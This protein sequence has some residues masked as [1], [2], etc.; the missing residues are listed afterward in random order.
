VNF[1]SGFAST[2][3]FQ[4][5]LKAMPTKKAEIV[6]SHTYPHATKA[7]KIGRDIDAN[8]PYKIAPVATLWLRTGRW[9]DG[10]GGV[11]TATVCGR[12]SG[13]TLV[14]RLSFSDSRSPRD[15]TRRRPST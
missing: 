9:L 7:Q 4:A 10:V 2:T 6:A 5:H 3:F 1:G 12:D 11:D 15:P 8:V 14:M 13:A